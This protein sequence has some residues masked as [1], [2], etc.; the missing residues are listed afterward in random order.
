VDG[1]KPPVL[2]N[3]FEIQISPRYFKDKINILINLKQA[4]TV[5]FSIYDMNGRLI[6]KSVSVELP[7]GSTIFI[8]NTKI[9]EQGAYLLFIQIGEQMVVEKIFKQ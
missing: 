5:D 1:I 7:G 8:F 3:D 4:T 2:V 9:V 6:D